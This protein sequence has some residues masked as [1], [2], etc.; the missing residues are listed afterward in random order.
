MGQFKL[1]SIRTA[2]VIPQ[3]IIYICS[4]LSKEGG[5]ISSLFLFI[6]YQILPQVDNIKDNI[7][8]KIQ[9]IA[10]ERFKEEDLSDCFILDIILKD[11]RVEVYADADQG[12]KFSQCQ[13][14]S[15]AI[16]AYL[17]ESQVIGEEYTIEVSSPGVDRPLQLYRQYPRN[18]DRELEV[19][20][21][22]DT[23]V[24]GKMTEVTEEQ[25]TLKVQGAKKGM[26]KLQIVPFEEVKS[27]RVLVSFK[28]KKKKK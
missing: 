27:T 3:H 25:I 7:K 13:K 6:V 1:S 24:T 12:I 28:K 15:R 17:D 26:F 20:L 5:S 14:L 8:E 23:V 9:Q 16:E 11:K 22:D 18:L 19:T 21:A 4:R 2:F 10:D